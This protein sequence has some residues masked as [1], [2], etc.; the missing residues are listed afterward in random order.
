MD[1]SF[2]FLRTLIRPDAYILIPVIYLIGLFLKQTPN[3]PE[4]SYAWI[5]LSFGIVA[6]LLYYGFEIS[7][8]NQGIL[9][10]GVAI[11]AK[12][13]IHLTADAAAAKKNDNNED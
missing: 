7:S 3:I 5:Q 8:V 9:T 6:C 10:A 11:L 1:I 12:D 13:L 2:E 4:W